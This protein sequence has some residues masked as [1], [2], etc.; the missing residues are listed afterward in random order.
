MFLNTHA[1]HGAFFCVKC[2]KF[3]GRE[4]IIKGSCVREEKLRHREEGT[5]Q[6][7][8]QMLIEEL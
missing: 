3:L 6:D 2:L 1:T 5:G 4:L 8:I 7:H